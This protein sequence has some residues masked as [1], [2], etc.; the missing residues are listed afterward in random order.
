VIRTSGKR[1]GSAQ[2]PNAFSEKGIG[3]RRGIAFIHADHARQLRDYIVF[4][5][6]HAAPG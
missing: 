4:A 6:I 3:R 1:I 2:S 5:Q